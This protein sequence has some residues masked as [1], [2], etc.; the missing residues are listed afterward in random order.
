MSHC[1]QKPQTLAQKW[2]LRSR[3][4]RVEELR[5]RFSNG[6]ERT[7]ERLNPG[8][9]RAVM[10]VAMPDPE[11]VVLVREYGAG[12]GD[13]YLSLA[14]GAIHEGEALFETA[15]RELKEEAGFGA[16]DFTFIKELYLSPSYMGNHIS[17]VL[18]TGLY[19]AS[20]PGDEPE[21]LQVE[22][23]RLADLDKLV[24]R[25]DFIEAYAVAA[26]YLAREHIAARHRELIS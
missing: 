6:A 5:L 1:R 22:T 12:I 3:L 14:K 4:F 7:Y 23:F 18:A 15:D 17:V 24:A 16:T 21:P 13:Y 20:L 19:E 11:T 26:L 9:H 25:Q 8:R 2:T 10:I